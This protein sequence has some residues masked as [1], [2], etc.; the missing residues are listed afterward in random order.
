[1]GEALALNVAHPLG[2][3]AS[4]G[5]PV[6]V[7]VE[8]GQATLANGT[9]TMTTLSTVM[10][11]AEQAGDA[12]YLPAR[13]TRSFNMR[14]ITLVPVGRYDT[15]GTAYNVQVVGNYAFVADGISGLQ[16]IDVTNP[17]NPMRV[18][19]AGTDAFFMS[20]QDVCV[21]GK[22]AYL[23]DRSS[24]VVNDVSSPADPVR[25]GTIG[26]QGISGDIFGVQVIGHYAYTS[27]GTYGLQMI[28][29]SNPAS[30]VRVGGI[31]LGGGFAQK[32]KVV[33]HYAYVVDTP[34][35]FSGAVGGGLHIIDVSDPAKPV[36]LGGYG[37]GS[38]A[39]GV[40]VTGNFA[41]VTS[42]AVDHVGSGRAEL[43]VIDVS[44]PAL[45]VKVGSYPTSERVNGVQVV[46]N[47]A[48]VVDMSE[49]LLV[50]D[51]SN[52]AKPVRVAGF[53]TG[54][55]ALGVQVVGNLVYVAS[56]SAGLQ[57]LE[58][59]GGYQQGVFWQGTTDEFLTL[60]TPHP[61]SATASSGLPVTLRVSN[62][63]AVI[64]DGKIT[65]TGGGTVVVT[66]EQAGDVTYAPVL[67]TRTF[68]VRQAFLT[69]VG[70]YD[71]SGSA[72]NVQVVGNYAYV[73]DDAAGLQ[74]IDVSNPTNPV[75][76]GGI[77][78]GGNALGVWVAGNYAYVACYELGL[79]VVDVSN[80]ATPKRVG[81]YD[82]SGSAFGVQ[83]LGNYAYVADGGAGLLVLDVTNPA[84]PVHLGGYGTG[85]LV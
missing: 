57:I 36:R 22:Y 65:V 72:N 49:G 32:V 27:A 82:T 26:R 63:P 73:A 53:A 19:G 37:A 24:I 59:K 56:G 40:D 69:P 15:S 45:S 55:E 68:N 5:L 2:A 46:G 16:V 39:N 14:E 51:V 48:F 33:G 18:G 66:A 64:A 1:M 77:I 25:V 20:S 30:L 71:T 78:I 85:G 34:T 76:V 13:L 3:T 17:A 52:P 62:G 67:A 80:P 12:T 6:T 42:R 41:Y 54:G 81:G 7:R 9:I 21:A 84:K 38:D 58:L 4:S 35:S 70:R 50:L 28:D 60:N 44:N 79:Q 74:V 8:S 31:A 23:A 83:V 47:H 75:R 11:T 61:L 29:V 10:V 43:Q